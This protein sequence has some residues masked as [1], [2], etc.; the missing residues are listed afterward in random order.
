M[1]SQRA[2][3][4]T[5][6]CRTGGGIVTSPKVEDDGSNLHPLAFVRAKRGW[7]QE[8]LALEIRKAGRQAGL[9]LATSKKTVAKWEHGVRPD[10]LAQAILAN[11]LEVPRDRMLEA[12]WPEWVPTGRIAGFGQGWSSSQE[13]IKALEDVVAAGYMDR[14][15]FLVLTGL[16]LQQPIYEWLLASIPVL[17]ASPSGPKVV[18]ETIDTINETISK[19]RLLGEQFGAGAIVGMVHGNLHLILELLRTA[20]Y[21]R[22]V[23]VRLYQTAAEVAQQAGW[24]SYD[25]SRHAAAQQYWVT[26][27]RLAHA[28]GDRLLGANVIGFMSYQAYS[29]GSA[30][31]ATSLASLVLNNAGQYLT[32]KVGAHLYGRLALAAARSGDAPKCREAIDRSLELISSAGTAAEP[33]W[34]SWLDQGQILGMVGRAATDIHDLT[35]AE[36]HLSR[37]IEL[38]GEQSRSRALFLGQLARAALL[39]ND[40]ECACLHGSA[41]FAITQDIRSPRVEGYLIDLGRDLRA[42]SESASIKQFTDL[43]SVFNTGRH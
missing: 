22:A 15:K 35:S 39:S 30:K 9:N 40:P 19:I 14:R 3:G 16:A 21:T 36:L 23:G 12:P 4:G 13:A 25:L 42:K 8:R 32:P 43:L 29:A 11:L 18:D 2:E 41:A 7:T 33:R 31:D 28:A 17:E 27:L 20:S 34:I 37:A 38:T 24:A 26:A 10:R 6:P 5:S 1:D